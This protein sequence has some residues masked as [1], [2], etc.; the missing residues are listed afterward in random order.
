MLR[1]NFAIGT[2]LGIAAIATTQAAAFSQT[3]IKAPTHPTLLEATM[4]TV[5]APQSQPSMSVPQTSQLQT[6]P[7][8]LSSGQ[9]F[10][11]HPPRLVRA[12]ASQLAARI[13]STYEFT[14]NVP[15]D[16]GQPLKAVTIAQA[17]NLEIVQFD[18]SQSKAFA[19]ERFAAGPEI[20][21]ASVG[22]MQSAP[23]EVTVVFDQPVQPGSTVTIAIPVAENPS[24]SG[25][26]EFGITAYPVGENSRG[27]F[28]GYGRINLYGN[29]N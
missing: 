7:T 14:L 1:I 19:G 13:A 29:S 20:S 10:F 26:Y 12:N 6:T 25:I 28:L 4:P 24:S 15:A 21:L 5:V 17:A 16:A 3:T 2:V 8:T 23:G 27:Q 22:G 9:Q 11:S 18:V